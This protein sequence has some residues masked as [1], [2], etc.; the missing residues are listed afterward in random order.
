MR[1]GY[2]GDFNLTLNEP[3]DSVYN[4]RRVPVNL[5][6]TKEVEKISYVNYYDSKPKTSVL[7][8]NCAEYGKFVRRVL[9]MNE[10]QNRVKFIA[11]DKSKVVEEE[12]SFFV[13]S[14]NPAILRNSPL[15]GFAKG[16][17]YLEFK[18]E[19]PDKVMLNYGN[20][21]LGFREKILNISEDCVPERNYVCNVWV[22]LSDYDSQQITYSF[23]VTDVAG[24]SV[25]S[26]ER[27][28]NVD[29][30]PPLINSLDWSSDGR[31]VHFVLNVTE[32]NLNRISYIDYS[33]GR[34]R[35]RSLCTR[36]K[37]GICEK[38]VSFPDGGHEVEIR[39]SDR[40]GNFVTENV[41]FFI[42]SKKPQIKK[43]SPM[44]GFASGKFY[45]N[46]REDNPASL[47]LHYGNLE[48]GM[49]MHSADIG[50]CIN[51]VGNYECL[52]SVDLADY[53]GQEVMYWFEIADGENVVVSRKVSLSVDTT[54]PV[55]TNP[56]SFWEQG[57]GRYTP[58]IYFQFNVA[59]ENFD[60]I[61]YIDKSEFAERERL[62]CSRL[63]NGVCEVRKQFGKGNH[64]LTISIRD[65]AGNS[66]EEEIYFFV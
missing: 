58:Y 59:E 14:K 23:N 51:Y 43:I 5:T 34:L 57:E 27:K 63:K 55:L 56:D 49:N 36:L 61:S 44:R 7:C 19:N 53:D 18:E 33:E 12:V 45:V 6:I 11:V 1:W 25:K 15:S 66:I 32:K 50:E 29:V 21:L 3:R 35:E 65:K 8:T 31:R 41:S 46:F 64:N 2:V 24:N 37:E 10:G 4:N 42:D 47:I 48:T 39:V 40:V 20:V 52:E 17:F 13:D 9:T 38:V 26:R 54:A 22:N 28:L 16:D 30:T 62:L 60:R